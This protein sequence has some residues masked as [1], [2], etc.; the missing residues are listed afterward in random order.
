MPCEAPVDSIN[1]LVFASDL[2][3]VAQTL[4]SI[5]LG[6]FKFKVKSSITIMYS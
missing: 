2:N 1:F 3:F 5:M 4:I 6:V